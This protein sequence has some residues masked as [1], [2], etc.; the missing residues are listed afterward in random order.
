MGFGIYLCKFRHGD[1][2][3]VDPATVREVLE[4]HACSEWG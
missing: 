3:P 2:V 1:V 4:P